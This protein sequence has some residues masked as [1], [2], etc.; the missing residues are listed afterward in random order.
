M[1]DVEAVWRRT[2]QLLRQ[3][4]K[5]S[6]LISEKDVKLFCRHAS[7]LSIQRGTSI[8]NEYDPKSIGT[9]EIGKAYTEIYLR[10]ILLIK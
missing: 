5:P 8:A 2:L 10:S 4:G 6:D 9:N 7:E 1:A 3:L